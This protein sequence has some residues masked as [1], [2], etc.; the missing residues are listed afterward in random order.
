MQSLVGTMWAGLRVVHAG[1]EDLSVR[2]KLGEVK[3]ERDAP[4]GADIDGLRAPRLGQR[5]VHR[6]VC[7]T[8]GLRRER[9][10][11][12]VTLDVDLRSPWH[13]LLEGFTSASSAFVASW[14]GGMRMLTFA[15]ATGTS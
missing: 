3:Q 13:V 8:A 5:G 15:R 6:A 1:D 7:R 2:E 11:D 12:R 10:A 4:A 14:P 9:L